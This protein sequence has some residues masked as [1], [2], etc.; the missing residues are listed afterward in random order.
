MN[1]SRFKSTR[2]TVTQG[3]VTA[4]VNRVMTQS[5]AWLGATAVGQFVIT[6]PAGGNFA[7]GAATLTYLPN[8]ALFL[9]IVNGRAFTSA[10]APPAFVLSGTTVLWTST[11]IGIAPT[12]SVTAVYSW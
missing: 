7:A 4:I 5:G 1:S 9:L 3:A 11:F 2:A 10:D 8:G 6:N 12:D